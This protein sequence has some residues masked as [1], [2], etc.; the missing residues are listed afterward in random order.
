MVG[1]SDESQRAIE[2]NN[3]APV[4]RQIEKCQKRRRY[5]DECAAEL[6]GA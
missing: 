6:A 2:L 4:L 1:L 3:V 5:W